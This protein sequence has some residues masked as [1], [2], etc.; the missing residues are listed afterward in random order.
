MRTLHYNPHVEKLM[1]FYSSHGDIQRRYFFSPNISEIRL[2]SLLFVLGF[3]PFFSSSPEQGPVRGLS[4]FEPG[5]GRG[6][7]V[8]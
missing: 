2:P 7:L 8:P 5:T 1:T 3:S 4:P 6:T